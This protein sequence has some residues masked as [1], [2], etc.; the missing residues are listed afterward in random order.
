MTQGS[1]VVRALQY[2]AQSSRALD[3]LEVARATA[4][5][6]A[7]KS[8]ATAGMAQEET[9]EGRRWCERKANPSPLLIA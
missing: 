2:V 1:V 3:G 7:A 6:K 5:T 9:R 4:A 8:R